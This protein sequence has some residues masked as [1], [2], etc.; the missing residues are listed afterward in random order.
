MKT[1]TPINRALALELE[2]LGF[3]I[4]LRYDV[5][6]IAW[7]LY[8]SQSYGGQGLGIR[9][10]TL[11]TRALARLERV[12]VNDVVLKPIA[13]FP[14][15]SAYALFGGNLN[16]H[17]AVCCCVD[18][19]C[20]VSHLS[21]MEFHG[22]TDRLPEQLYVSSPAGT[23]WTSFALQ[24]MSKDLGGDLAEY[25]SAGLPLLRRVAFT[26]IG[27]RT[28]HRF[29]SS[30]LGAYRTIKDSPVRVATIGRTFLDML[31]EPVLCG[32]IAHVLEVFQEHASANRRLILDELDQQGS[33]IDKVR[34]G[35]LLEEV[36]KIRDQ[37]IDA[38]V[39]FAARGG[40]RKLDATAE[41]SPRF[42]ERWSL[43]IN[44][45]MLEGQF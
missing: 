24:R 7:S 19:F 42:S 44:V 33:A 40:S 6:R 36:C 20:Y 23:Q 16:D 26:K 29:A 39:Q 12:L 18:P 28:V 1:T 45:P 37:R 14:G 10:E 38:W 27:G 4:V 5:S 31:R 30:H 17:R 35:Y 32:G 25:E 11:D 43:S 34:A 8:K 9:R 21:A 3:P 13:G 41:Y 22:L 2:K 15:R